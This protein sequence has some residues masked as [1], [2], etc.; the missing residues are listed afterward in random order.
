MKIL[1]S[2][3]RFELIGYKFTF[4]TSIAAHEKTAQD[5]VLFS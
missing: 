5:Q 4:V 3:F 2:W 1:I